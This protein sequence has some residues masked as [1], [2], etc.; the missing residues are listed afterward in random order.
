MLPATPNVAI[1]GATGAVG[2]E[3]LELFVDRGVAHGRLALLASARSAG[4]HLP[5]C[6]TSIAV[7]EATPEAFEGIDLAYFSAGSS[8]SQRLA[9][10]AVARGAVVID[11]SSA[12]RMDEE[13][14]LVIPEINGDLLD[15]MEAPGIIAN[16]NCSTI[17]AL[18]AIAPIHRAVGVKRVSAATYQAVSGAGAAWMGELEQQARDFAA[19]RPLT[20]EVTGRR[21]LF[22]VFSHD[23][24][25]GPDGFNEEERKLGRESRKIL[26]APDLAVTATCVR[27]PVLRAHAE[28][29]DLELAAPLDADEARA[30]LAAAPGVRIV[31]D[32]VGNRFPEPLD[33]A[34]RDEVLVGRIRNDPSRPKGMGLQLFVCGDQLRKGA[35]LNAI[36][37]AERMAARSPTARTGAI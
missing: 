9:R 19:G 1:V 15:A 33:A 22:N 20:T 3:L 10:E 5:Y 11:N 32:A 31:E 18:L 2:A 30:I 34:G 4:T 25:I 24:A 8:I 21:L 26:G 13:V 7:Q 27:V 35:A 12:Y 16:P 29:L 28:A 37:I 14:P 23:S 6:G 17:I 36:Q